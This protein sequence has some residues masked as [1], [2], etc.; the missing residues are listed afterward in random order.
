VL[1]ERNVHADACRPGRARRA[2]L[3]DVAAI[4]ILALLPLLAARPQAA[5]GEG[6]GLAR[7]RQGARR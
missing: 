3:Q 5:A 1:A 4:P 7:R 6:G 2:L